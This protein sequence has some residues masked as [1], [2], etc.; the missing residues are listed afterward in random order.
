MSKFEERRKETEE[1]KARNRFT[2]DKIAELC[3]SLVNT[4]VGSLIIG[5]VLLLLQD[6]NEVKQ[7]YIP[8][9]LV[10]GVSFTVVFVM[11]GLKF[12]K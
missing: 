12:F 5:V 8:A 11:I 3:F 4:L 2:R 6:D 10:A 1:R 7:E 9:V